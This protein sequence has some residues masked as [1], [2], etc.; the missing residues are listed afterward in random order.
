MTEQASAPHSIPVP[1]SE[2][3]AEE[4][5]KRAVAL[6]PALLERQ[7][8]CERLRELPESTQRDFLAAGFYRILQPRRFGGYEFGPE[9]FARTMAE[10]ARGCPSSAWVLALT[11]GHT[12]TLAHFAEETQVEFYGE[13]GDFRCPLV[14]LPGGKGTPVEG[15]YRV[16]G[17]WDYASGCDLATHFMGTA[18]VAADDGGRPVPLL[19][20]VPR[21]DF[22]IVDNWDSMGM[23]GTGSRRVVV[24]DVFVPERHAIRQPTPEQPAE[25]PGRGT[26]ANPY[27][28]GPITSMLFIELTAVALGTARGALDEYEAILRVRETY[29]PPVMP[30]TEHHEF[31]RYFGQAFA[32]VD[33]AEAALQRAC[34]DYLDLCRRE[35][36]E[37]IPFGDREDRRLLLYLQQAVRLLADAVDVLFRTAGTSATRPEARLQRYFRDFAVVRTH[38]TMQYDRTAENYAA[39]HFGLR[40]ASML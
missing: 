14:G 1:E 2:L 39:M 19:V 26:H 33:V 22:T 21:S 17:A 32:L 40:P 28:L 5:V 23:R 30:R 27:Y 3:T 9:V 31:Q 7:Q 15:G 35:A 13:D 36:E 24:E 12:H 18:L 8:E 16:S 4:M 10:I 37:G 38:V 11:A 29:F 6:R 20:A 34:R 25:H